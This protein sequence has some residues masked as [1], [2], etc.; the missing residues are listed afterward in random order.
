MKTWHIPSETAPQEVFHN[1]AKI[2]FSERGS[3]VGSMSA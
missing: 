2:A 3:L 1:L